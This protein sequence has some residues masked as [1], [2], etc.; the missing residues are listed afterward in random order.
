MNF[1]EAA[2]HFK[3]DKGP[4]R[5]K[6]KDEPGHG[7]TFA[8][9]REFGRFFNRG[10]LLEIGVQMGCSLRLWDWY[11]KD[12]FHGRELAEGTGLM[13]AKDEWTLTGL[14]LSLVP[15]LLEMP[16]PERTRIIEGDATDEA[17]ILSTAVAR[18]P[19]DIII[20]DGSHRPHHQLASLRGFWPHLKVGGI[21]CI[22]DLHQ[23]WWPAAF[24]QG[25]IVPALTQLM[26]DCI[27]RGKFANWS[28]VAA[29][30]P[31]VRPEE[32]ILARMSVYR[33]LVILEKKA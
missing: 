1:H 11:F 18:G 15:G 22:E 29:R 8:Y 2:E 23:S 30:D 17:T 9:E 28:G 26:E 25:S 7:Y 14:E 31:V 27:G 19:F 12:S 16:W 20:D 3:T 6:A 24:E 32:E 33:N 4:W 5:N 13:R 10:S 21:Y